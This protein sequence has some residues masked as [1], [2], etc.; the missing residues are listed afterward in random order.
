VNKINVKFFEKVKHNKYCGVNNN[1]VPTVELSSKRH[2]PE[3]VPN[4]KPFKCKE[5]TT[6]LKQYDSFVL[7]FF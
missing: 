1:M 7:K 4:T 6:L 2:V 3:H 5:G